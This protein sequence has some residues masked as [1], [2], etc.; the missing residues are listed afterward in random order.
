MS[1]A[2]YEMVMPFVTV[3]SKGGPHDDDSY[4]AG[5]IMGTLNSSLQTA[6][7]VRASI[8]ATIEEVNMPQAELIAMRNGYALTDESVEDFPGW[9][10]VTFKPGVTL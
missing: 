2:E 7:T 10:F 6:A 8:T 5:Y 4:V 3:T 1:D 9:H